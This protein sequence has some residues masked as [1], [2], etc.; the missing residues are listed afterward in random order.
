MANQFTFFD[1]ASPNNPAFA[2]FGI[3]QFADEALVTVPLNNYSRNDLYNRVY[4]DGGVGYGDGGISSLADALN[5][6]YN[7]FKQNSI[8]ENRAI[9]LVLNDV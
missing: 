7:Q 5:V 4:G 9:V 8:F 3:I 6:A 1:E 2:R